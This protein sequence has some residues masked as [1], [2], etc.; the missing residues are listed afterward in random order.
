MNQNNENHNEWQACP[1]G[2]VGRLV[3]GLQNRNRALATQRRMV[4][5]ALLL[6]TAFTGYY[7]VGVL[8]NAEPNYGGIVCSRLMELAPQFMAGTLDAEAS[9]WVKTHLA[10]C[11]HCRNTLQAMDSKSMPRSA[12]RVTLRRVE[13]AVTAHNHD[14]MTEAFASLDR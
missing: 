12:S 3:D 2:E 9:S 5:A 4:A 6:M 11:K 1:P 14:G 10:H 8:P 7:F 13:I